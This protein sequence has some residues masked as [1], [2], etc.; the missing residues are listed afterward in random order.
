MPIISIPLG[1][2][3]PIEPNSQPPSHKDDDYQMKIN[4]NGLINAKYK[5]EI[6]DYLT[7]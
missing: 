7:G 1:S 6:K 3:E 2:N 5:R 4:L